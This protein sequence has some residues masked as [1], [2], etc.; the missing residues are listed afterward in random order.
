MNYIH[1]YKYC[2]NV[3]VAYGAKQCAV[4][5]IINP[6]SFKPPP[7]HKIGVLVVSQVRKLK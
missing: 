7:K 5:F 4:C 6:A 3:L 1:G 2:Q